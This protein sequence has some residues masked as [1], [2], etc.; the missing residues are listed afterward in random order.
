MAPSV[1][2]SSVDMLDPNDD[3]GAIGEEER[4]KNGLNSFLG[5]S[6]QLVDF[7]CVVGEDERLVGVVWLAGSYG[8]AR[9]ARVAWE[10]F[11]L[12]SHGNSL[13]A[14]RSLETDG[15][16]SH[17]EDERLLQ[18]A[19]EESNF[20]DALSPPTRVPSFS[21]AAASSASKAR[22]SGKG[23]KRILRALGIELL[24]WAPLLD[25]TLLRG[26]LPTLHDCDRA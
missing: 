10:V 12:M 14:A 2:I 26:V 6:V 18:P 23:A 19:S 1:S 8:S 15:G 3:G 5:L 21:S 11:R 17:V 9:V 22:G 20:M 7:F 24:R 16:E 4:R 13:S 25:A